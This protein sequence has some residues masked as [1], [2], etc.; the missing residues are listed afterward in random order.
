MHHHAE[1]EE[2]KSSSLKDLFLAYND[3]SSVKLY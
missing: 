2:N 1:G 3:G